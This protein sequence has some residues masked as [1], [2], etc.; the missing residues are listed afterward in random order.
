MMI[1]RYGF[2][3]KLLANNLISFSLDLVKTV[4]EYT[5]QKDD[6]SPEMLQRIALEE[7]QR[8]EE[9]KEQLAIAK[10]LVSPIEKNYL[11][12]EAAKNGWLSTLKFLGEF[13]N[14][15]EITGT[16]VWREDE[17][18]PTTLLLKACESLYSN[19][20]TRVFIINKSSTITIN[21]SN[22][23]P[24]KLS[25]SMPI[26]FTLKN[27]DL[28]ATSL[29]LRR[30]AKFDPRFQFFLPSDY[31]LLSLFF[32]QAPERAR[33]LVNPMFGETLERSQ[34]LTE[35]RDRF[36]QEQKL[37]IALA[38]KIKNLLIEQIK[39]ESSFRG[40]DPERAQAILDA[41][42]KCFTRELLYMLLQS[43]IACFENKPFDAKLLITMCILLDERLINP[44][45]MK[46]RN[47]ATSKLYTVLQQMIN[48]TEQE[49]S[50]QVVSVISVKH[51][52]Q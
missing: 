50:K 15:N 6:K 11:A 30:G 1:A 22:R 48:I 24:Y 20:E 41:I 38:K 42:N 2:F 5:E 47:P 28:E 19:S 3:G 43:Q 44:V 8:Q 52:G 4:A 26:D 9:D 27:S 13:I 14:F 23:N 29:L 25:G 21:T 35:C 10:T 17:R 37:T 34:Y 40:G 7:K 12:S 51:Q 32:S 33:S 49:V 36:L 39:K 18:Q 31:L 16:D 46:N 45:L